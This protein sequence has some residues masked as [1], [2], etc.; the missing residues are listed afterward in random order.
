VRA[1]QFSCV[2]CESGL[3]VG[4]INKKL[5]VLRSAFLATTLLGPW[6]CK[7]AVYSLCCAFPPALQERWRASRV[8]ATVAQ[9]R[10]GGIIQQK[11]G[12]KEKRGTNMQKSREHAQQCT[13][14]HARGIVALLCRARDA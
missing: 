11:R 6:Y 3:R 4:N 13:A 14:A 12:R 7:Q 5:R 1:R 2:P 9:T 10:A 8:N